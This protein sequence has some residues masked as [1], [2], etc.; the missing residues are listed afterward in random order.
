MDETTNEKAWCDLGPNSPVRM[1]RAGEGYQFDI[2]ADG[3][4]AASFHLSADEVEGMGS[5]G[6]CQVI[7]DEGS[8]M[9]RSGQGRVW[10]VYE[11]SSTG[12]RG[13][14][15]LKQYDFQSVM[16]RIRAYAA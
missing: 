12:H 16:Q 13:S 8:L 2:V 9:L 14:C 7:S 5:A 3:A 1:S 11:V 10:I 15:L 4:V 6:S